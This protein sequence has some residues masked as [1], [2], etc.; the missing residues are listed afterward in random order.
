MGP[1]QPCITSG[2]TACGGAALT[3]GPP[4]GC[5]ERATTEGQSSGIV[6]HPVRSARRMAG[7]MADT[8]AKIVARV[9]D[10]HTTRGRGG[11]DAAGAQGRQ[12]PFAAGGDRHET[13][14]TAAVHW[15]H[16]RP[17]IR[18]SGHHTSLSRMAGCVPA[19]LVGVRRRVL[20]RRDVLPGIRRRHDVA[21]RV[22]RHVAGSSGSARAHAR[23]A[24]RSGGSCR[25]TCVCSGVRLRAASSP[26]GSVG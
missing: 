7:G 21:A 5:P 18:T 11:I 22:S 10:V 20:R 8:V 13:K 6:T 4:G 25:A 23:V 17:D 19:R 24:R 14:R 15:G 16:A 12:I 1:R 26:G 2:A 9:G 3:R